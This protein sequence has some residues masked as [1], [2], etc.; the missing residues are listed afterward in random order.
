MDTKQR[1]GAKIRE[2]RKRKKWTQ[3]KLSEM[4]DINPRQM[5]R[6]EMGQNLPT[7][8]N[9]ENIAKNLGVSI[10][11][12]FNND[13]FDD[14]NSLKKKINSKIESLDDKSLR[15]LYSVVINL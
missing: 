8:E 10:S 11:D 15:F 1:L 3:E 9:L 2:L 13:C 4:I 12:L 6:I 7:I 5:V 14:N